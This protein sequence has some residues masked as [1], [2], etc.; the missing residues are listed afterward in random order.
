M[1]ADHERFLREIEDL[2][3]DQQREWEKASTELAKLLMSED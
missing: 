1:M 3:E 2:Q